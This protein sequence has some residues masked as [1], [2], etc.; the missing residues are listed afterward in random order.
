LIEVGDQVTL[1]NV[2]FFPSDIREEHLFQQIKT[3]NISLL[4]DIVWQDS[5]ELVLF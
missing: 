5:Q 1:L 4:T 3:K 2:C